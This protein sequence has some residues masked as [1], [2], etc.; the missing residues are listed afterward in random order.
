MHYD[1][2]ASTSSV[3]VCSERCADDDKCS[4]FSLDTKLSRCMLFAQAKCNMKRGAWIS[5]IKRTD[6]SKYP[7]LQ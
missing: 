4:S 6:P 3:E 7:V 5:G 2:I 1:V